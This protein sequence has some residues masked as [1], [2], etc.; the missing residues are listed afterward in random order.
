MT[1]EIGQVYDVEVVEEM[2]NEWTGALGIALIEDV[3]IPIP[4]AKKGEHF[5][6]KI[7]G[8]GTNQWT[9]KKEAQFEK[10]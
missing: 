1:A 6:I 2:S 9:G 3:E 7:L 10:L 4:K 5:S 8:V